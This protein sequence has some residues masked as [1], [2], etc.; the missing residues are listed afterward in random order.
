M[1]SNGRSFTKGPPDGKRSD[2]GTIDRGGAAAVP[3][4]DDPKKLTDIAVRN[5]EMLLLVIGRGGGHECDSTAIELVITEVGGQARAWDLAKDVVD[6]LPSGN[7]L[8]DSQGNP[9]V[10]SFRETTTPSLDQPPFERN[11]QASSA[12]EFLEELA[13]K[14]LATIRQRV[15]QRTEQ[16]WDG[17]IAA[18]FPDKTMP[19]IPKPAFDTPMKVEV[20]CEKLSAQ[21]NLGAWHL[22]RHAV[23]NDQ[24]QLR[25]ND[26]PYGI[27][28]SETYLVLR[29][30]DLM[31]M[32]K[33]AADGLDQWLGL[34]IENT[35][36]PGE[37]GHHAWAKPDRP[38]E[39]SPTARLLHE[40]R[41]SRGHRWEHGWHSQLWVP[42]RSC[43]PLS[44]TSV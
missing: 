4:Q 5:G 31:G 35:V 32:H 16:T 9:E 29:A 43:S 41:R 26:Y 24:G 27:L 22:S 28:A 18:M 11:S 23:K 13:A 30:L 19:A 6:H 37:G 15:R 34:P 44:N 8:P 3:S 7:L 21:W 17:A 42:A 36:V 10:W 25:F 39:I 33:E 38:W 20:P 12:Q 14:N 2:T 40:R 1:A